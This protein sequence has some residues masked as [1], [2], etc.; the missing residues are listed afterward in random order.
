MPVRPAPSSGAANASYELQPIR[1]GAQLGATPDP[2]AGR[3]ASSRP[4]RPSIN[5]S[6]GAQESVRN[7]I[8]SGEGD[9]PV[10]PSQFRRTQAMLDEVVREMFAEQGDLGMMHAADLDAGHPIEA[11]L[12]P[13]SGTAP[14]GGPDAAS[15]L[16]PRSSQDSEGDLG[17]ARGYARDT[18]LTAPMLPLSRSVS[19][20]SSTSN[21]SAPSVN[22]STPPASSGA[23]DP[24]VAPGAPP[25][26][27]PSPTLRSTLT[28]P[29]SRASTSSLDSTRP[30]SPAVAS[31]GVSP[32]VSR[33]MP[34]AFHDSDEDDGEHD[35]LPRFTPRVGGPGSGMQSHLIGQMR[36]RAVSSADDA[37]APTRATPSVASSSR[38]AQTAEVAI[39]PAAAEALARMPVWLEGLQKGGLN[40]LNAMLRDGGVTTVATFLRELIGY[41]MANSSGMSESHK[42]AVSSTIMGLTMFMNLGA[43]AR[44]YQDGTGNGRTRSY[45][46]LNVGLLALAT[47]VAAKTDT[48]AGAAPLLFKGGSYCVVRDTLNAF[49]TQS[50]ARDQHGQPP[51]HRVAA[52]HAVLVAAIGMA[53]NWGQSA[54]H[55]IS[56]TGAASAQKALVS[57]LGSIGLYS[58]LNGAGEALDGGTLPYLQAADEHVRP[59]AASAEET[60][61]Q[62]PGD[63]KLEVKAGVPTWGQYLDKVN[64]TMTGRASIFATLYGLV[65]AID[66]L[67]PQNPTDAANFMNA[68]L[69]LML[70]AFCPIFIGSVSTSPAPPRERS[71]DSIV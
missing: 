55:V 63:V 56:G 52:L 69:G 45:Q 50:D 10:T 20:S 66:S 21:G 37:D 47:G 68:T 24:V 14:H 11:H 2:A 6:R 31:P 46:A 41:A 26:P 64:G 61:R 23:T 30:P 7:R 3:D 60:R 25:P 59:P 57:A 12:A 27:L 48:L 40:Y 42:L 1:S 62:G 22:T 18:S 33:M 51:S 53:V 43:M 65:G 16:R 38:S 54:E 49:F 4:S 29:L 17:L 15:T 8:E 13:Q 71:N 9:T 44:Q 28:R 19:Q 5:T 32:A 58:L 36:R 39:P 67:K 35:I 70:G 34:G